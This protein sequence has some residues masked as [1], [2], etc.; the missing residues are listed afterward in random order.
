MHLKQND[1]EYSGVRVDVIKSAQPK[2][3]TTLLGMYAYYQKER[4]EIY[5]KKEIEKL[6]RPWSDNPIFQDFKFTM[7]KRWLDRES[8]NLINGILSR[9][10]VSLENK[11]LNSVAFRLIN[12]WKSFDVLPNKYI[13]YNKDWSEFDWDEL[14]KHIRSTEISGFFTDAYFV[15]GT[16]RALR[17]L[18]YGNDKNIPKKQSNPFD[19]LI[20]IYKYVLSNKDKFIAL[21]K[22]EDPNDI[23][24][25][26]GKVYGLGKF[27]SYQIYSDWTYIKEFPF[28]DNSCVDIGP[29]TERGL[30]HLFEDFDGMTLKEAVYWIRENIERVCHENDLEW[31]LN[32]WFWFLEEHQRVW[33]LQDITNSFCEFDKLTRIWDP[34][35]IEENRRRVR[36]Y[37]GL[38]D[39]KKLPKVKKSQMNGCYDGVSPKLF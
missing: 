34:V 32:K 8:K 33:T 10:D 11:L 38:V 31:D 5:V 39:K 9:E 22:L 36:K 6:E 28:S 4:T 3:N 24:T 35:D 37:A 20:V 30:K 2:L 23:V 15:S 12:K 17:L 26:L 25:E 16:L 19:S 27:L 18:V 7:T 21:S 14:S 1:P 29:G 13:D